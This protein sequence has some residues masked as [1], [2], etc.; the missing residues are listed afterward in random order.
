MCLQDEWRG[1]PYVNFGPTLEPDSD[2]AIIISNPTSAIENHEFRDIPWMTGVVAD[3]GLLKTAS[4]IHSYWIIYLL[5]LIHDFIFSIK[6]LYSDESL[7]EALEDNFKEAIPMFL[8]MEGVVAKPSLFSGMLMDFYFPKG[9]QLD[10][11]E[12]VDNVTEVNN[13]LIF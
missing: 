6:E 11:S 13:F 2:D 12:A 10:S 3:E 5:L 7:R 1:H 9:M 4:M 8:E